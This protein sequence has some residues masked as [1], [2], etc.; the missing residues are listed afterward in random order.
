MAPPLQFTATVAAPE[1]I[2]PRFSFAVTPIILVSLV[3]IPV[4]A[5]ENPVV[6]ES[7]IAFPTGN[8]GT[9]EPD[10]PRYRP[11]P[12][13]DTPSECVSPII[14]SF[15]PVKGRTGWLAPPHDC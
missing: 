12:V 13:T 4:S 8:S 7:T 11:D 14:T 5:P 2:A 1:V 6:P 9:S 3:E 10:A 15:A